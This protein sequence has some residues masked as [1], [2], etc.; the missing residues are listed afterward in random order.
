M[1]EDAFFSDKNDEIESVKKSFKEI[2]EKC[3]K[4]KNIVFFSNIGKGRAELDKRSP[5]IYSMIQEFIKN[6]Q[7]NKNC[8]VINYRKTDYKDIGQNFVHKI[9]MRSDPN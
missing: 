2:E 8:K 7:K 4:G 9:Y 1:N 5:K 6:I 3:N